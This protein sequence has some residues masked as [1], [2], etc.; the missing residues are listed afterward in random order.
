MNATRQILQVN[1]ESSIF[2]I[3]RKF[4]NQKVEVIVFSLES[5]KDKSET[6]TDIIGIWKNRFDSKLSS[7]EIK[8]SWRLKQWTR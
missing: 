3:P 4:M 7:V 8:K 6:A 5:V 1:P 2:K